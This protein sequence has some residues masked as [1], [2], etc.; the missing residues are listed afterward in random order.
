MVAEWVASGSAWI[1]EGNGEGNG[2][3]QGRGEQGNRGGEVIIID[4]T[5]EDAEE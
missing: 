3:G 1:G 5:M 4:G 2:E